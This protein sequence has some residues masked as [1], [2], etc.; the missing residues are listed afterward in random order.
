M[1]S[2]RVA[3]VA[4][5]V[6]IWSA[7][8]LGYPGLA[9]AET[10]GAQQG[11]EQG[12]QTSEHSSAPAAETEPTPGATKPVRRIAPRT[13]RQAQTTARAGLSS[14]RPTGV[15]PDI[16]EAEETEDT[17]PENSGT[18][19]AP[20]APARAQVQTAAAPVTAA[21]VPA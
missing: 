11:P 17:E 4:V 20:S 13:V 14:P 16:P 9:L 2:G 18:S 1:R 15:T 10:P 6:G 5:V 7:T 8:G 21:V 3:G 12:E 19:A